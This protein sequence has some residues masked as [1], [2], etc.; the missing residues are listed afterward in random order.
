LQQQGDFE[1]ERVAGQ[2]RSLVDNM[3]NDIRSLQNLYLEAKRWNMEVIFEDALKSQ[4]DMESDGLKVQRLRV[5]SIKHR[6][7][8]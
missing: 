7:D 2:I 4:I 3:N 6:V 8:L 5:Q 1:R